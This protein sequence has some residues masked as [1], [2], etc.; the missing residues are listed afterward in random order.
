MISLP[1]DLIS[2]LEIQRP[3]SSEDEMVV[4]GSE[5]EALNSTKE[6]QEAVDPNTQRVIPPP[7][8]I[9]PKQ[10]PDFEAPKCPLEH[11]QFM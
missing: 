8:P 2:Q 4:A 3:A 5:I 11:I 1:A 9:L 7:L 10:L 6:Q